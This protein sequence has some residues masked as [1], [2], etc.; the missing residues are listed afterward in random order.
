MQPS[1]QRG[2]LLCLAAALV[3]SGTAPGIAYLLDNHGVAPLALAFWRDA[4]I[5]VACLA[6]V[7]GAAF[8]GGRRFPR[9]SF[10]ELRGFAL[11]GVISVGIYHA[12]FVISIALNGAALGIVL[13]YLYP[14][15]VTLGARLIFKETIGPTQVVALVLA[16]VGSALLV[17]IYDPAVLRVSWLGIVVGVLSAVTHAGYVLFSQRAVTS[18][19]PWLSLAL[20]MSFGALALLVLT[21]VA[22]GPAAL[23]QVGSGWTPWLA[24]VALALGPTLMGY[25]LF[26]SSLRH[27]P[28]RVAS[29]I[30]VIEAP[31]TTLAAVLLLGERIEP[32]Q[33]VGI[34]LILGAAVLPGL[35]ARLPRR[36]ARPAAAD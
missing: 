16:L 12:L 2:Y 14:A 36:A 27:I 33:T 6:G 21:L 5:A 35:Q 19:S 7:A 4:L 3:W 23:L 32:A 26:T 24:L 10:A 11:I 31:I 30:V 29:V 13:I 22:E 1:P 25:G 28:G 18:H 15:F 34:A 9:L 8:A 17:R 20:T